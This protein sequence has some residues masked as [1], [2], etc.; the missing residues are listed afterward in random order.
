VV[1]WP[2]EL[3]RTMTPGRLDTIRLGPNDASELSRI[4]RRVLGWVPT[5][6]LEEGLARTVEW[7]R[8]VEQRS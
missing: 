4:V 5:V 8:T 3:S 1:D 2:I 6:E 7:C